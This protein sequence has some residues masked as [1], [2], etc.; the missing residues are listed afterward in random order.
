MKVSLWSDIRTY[1]KTK[2]RVPLDERQ[3]ETQKDLYMEL[4]KSVCLAFMMYIAIMIFMLQ[5]EVT[6][7]NEVM[8]GG[9]SALGTITYFYLLRF[10]YHNIV[11]VDATFEVILV[12]AFTFIPC[13]FYYSGNILLE[14][15]HAPRIAY[16]MMACCIPIFLLVTYLGA[17]K[18]YQNGKAQSLQYIQKEEQHFHSRRILMTFL[19][20]SFIILIVLPIPYYA[21]FKVCT[22]SSSIFVLYNIYSYG[23]TTPSNDYILNNEGL[24]FRKAMW[25]KKGKF[26]PYDEIEDISLQDTFNI[27]YAKDKVRISCKDGTKVYLYPE[28]AY[29][30][31]S[32]LN[33]C[34]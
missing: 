22:V 13:T 24:S 20:I 30:F 12:P 3:L 5:F 2:D 29:Q 17:N 15:F 31:Y 26:I 16:I 18:V 6:L 34:L 21:L 14:L 7:T 23:F 1:S 25:G 8:M 33:N 10:C 28:N 4:A 11:G 32:E 19:I 9:V 27:G